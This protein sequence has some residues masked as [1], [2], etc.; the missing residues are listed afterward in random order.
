MSVPARAAFTAST[1]VQSPR[2]LAVPSSESVIV[3]PPK[4][5]SWRRSVVAIAKDQPAAGGG[6]GGARARGGGRGRQPVPADLRRRDGGR[7]PRDALDRA[8]FLV[9]ADQ[10]RRLAT[11]NGRLVKLS[12]QG[13]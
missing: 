11:V 3:T 7:R 10:E 1:R 6:R 13:N 9:D 12:R 4:P 2:A 8:A 5:R